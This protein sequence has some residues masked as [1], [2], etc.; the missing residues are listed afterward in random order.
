MYDIFLYNC[1]L[2]PLFLG[3]TCNAKIQSFYVQYFRSTIQ[4]RWNQFCIT[5]TV[6]ICLY[7]F[8]E[9]GNIFNNLTAQNC[10]VTFSPNQCVYPISGDTSNY[11][12]A[13]TMYGSRQCVWS[14]PPSPVVYHYSL[15]FC[16]WYLFY[17]LETWNMEYQ[18][19]LFCVQHNCP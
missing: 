5:Y 17:L 10:L 16:L 3:F 18:Y 6:L 15:L 8:L 7:P 11:M 2:M 12:V 4:F 1:C 19:L 14:S 13:F 9:C